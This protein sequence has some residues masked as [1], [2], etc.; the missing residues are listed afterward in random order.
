MAPRITAQEKSVESS[1]DLVKSTEETLAPVN[2][3]KLRLASN[4]R[5]AVRLPLSKRADVKLLHVK[6]ELRSDDVTNCAE[7]RFRKNKSA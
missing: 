6:K 1:C 7:V 4:I 3:A 2:R 5:D